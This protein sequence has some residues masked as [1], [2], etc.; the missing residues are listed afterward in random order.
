MEKCTLASAS[1]VS[2]NGKIVDDDDEFTESEE[3][4]KMISSLAEVRRTA[5]TL[6]LVS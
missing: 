2:S 4:K 1:A 6:C 3:Q 5:L